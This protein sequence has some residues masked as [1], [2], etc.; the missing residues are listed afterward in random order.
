MGL[1]CSWW[2][3]TF[4][5]TLRVQEVKDANVLRHRINECFEIASLP[6]T[7]EDKRKELLSFV[8][9]LPLPLL[10]KSHDFVWQLPLMTL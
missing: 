1:G 2:T 4:C 6:D 9:V 10:D 7:P 3:L 8:L 5:G